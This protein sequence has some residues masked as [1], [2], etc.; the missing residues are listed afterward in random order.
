MDDE[1]KRF[2][3]DFSTLTDLAASM[4]LG[5][6]H[7]EQVW[8]AVEAHFGSTTAGIPAV[9]EEFGGHRLADA[10]IL[11]SGMDG[12][13]RLVGVGSEERHHLSLGD[14]LQNRRHHRAPIAEPDY[15]TVD[16]GP[17]QS[18]RIVDYGL[19]LVDGSH[20]RL[21]VLLRGPHPQFG[22]A[23][24]SLEILG[25]RAEHVDAFTSWFRAEMRAQSI[26]R[27]H[28]VSF[29]ANEFEPTTGGVTFHRR[30]QMTPGDIILPSGVLSSV[31]RQ[32][33]ELGRHRAALLRA[34]QHLKRGVLLYGPPGTGKTHLVRYL[35]S[36]S[37]GTTAILLS[38]GSLSLVAEAARMARALQ[39]A[40]VVLEDC[41][42]VAEDR[43][44]GMGAQPL[45]FEL[46]EA[47][48]G[49]DADADVAF[50]LTT[51]RVETLERA[52]AQRP[53]RVDL[54]VEI[55]KPGEAE[56]RALL[57]LYAGSL[58]FSEETLD[59]AAE[60]TGGTTA[61][62]AKELVR[63][64]VLRAALQDR[65]VTDDDLA[66]TVEELMAAQSALTR[67][68]LGAGSP[69]NPEDDDEVPDVDGTAEGLAY[70]SSFGWAPSPGT[71]SRVA[72]FID[73]P[74][75]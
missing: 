54:A 26:Y 65:D 33:I 62:F 64:S 3:A 55:P 40:I 56:R 51:N 70:G 53:G 44:F 50:V 11:L 66:A 36:R 29:S 35:L 67:S 41:D 57:G 63:R 61:S 60:Q 42:L 69:P 58:G 28:V 18:R 52:L 19:F 31:E 13:K 47:M 71:E 25:G 1:L 12:I 45:L 68:L 72:G 17:D 21:A 74:E 23:A 46:L 27:R 16:V 38:A 2:L 14:L 20:G 49:L 73:D 5:E 34:G 9:T 30:P 10:S 15:R 6:H 37:A 4:Q 8:D 59:R 7:G 48:D 75:G 32:V 39:P 43:G 22:R 24:A